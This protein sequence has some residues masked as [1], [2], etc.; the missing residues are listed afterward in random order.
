MLALLQ[1]LPEGLRLE[2]ALRERATEAEVLAL[3]QELPEGLRLEEALRERAPEAE[4]EREGAAEA[5]VATEFRRT[6]PWRPGS[7]PLL[8]P[9]TEF[10]GRP[11]QA[12]PETTTE[13]PTES[14]RVGAA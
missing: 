9:A 6:H 11:A 4:E 10:R 12:A 13:P 1:E 2:E 5:E 7:E 14:P 3:L 8:E